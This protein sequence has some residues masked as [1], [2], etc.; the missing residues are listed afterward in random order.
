MLFNYPSEVAG[1][2]GGYTSGTKPPLAL[3]TKTFIIL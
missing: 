3:N 1:G 2:T